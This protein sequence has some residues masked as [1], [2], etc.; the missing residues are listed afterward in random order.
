MAKE[1]ALW[2]G[3]PFFVAAVIALIGF[4]ILRWAFSKTAVV[5]K[6]SEGFVAEEV[7]S[8]AS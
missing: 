2:Y 6:D 5:P 1:N 8:D 7:E 4:V 3:S